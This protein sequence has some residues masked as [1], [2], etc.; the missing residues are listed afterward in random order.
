M[1][2]LT[3][4]GSKQHQTKLLFYY[5]FYPHIYL[6]ILPFKMKKSRSCLTACL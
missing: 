4:S 5:L 6:I 3:T 1:P 2:L